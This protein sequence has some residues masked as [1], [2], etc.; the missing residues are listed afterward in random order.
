[1]DICGVLNGDPHICLEQLMSC[2]CKGEEVSYSMMTID[3]CF[4]GILTIQSY[5]KN[6][7]LL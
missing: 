6:N 7:Q 4:D 1:M 5:R 3:V 2:N